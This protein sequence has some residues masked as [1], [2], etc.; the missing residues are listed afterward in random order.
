MKAVP[1]LPCKGVQR[2]CACGKHTEGC[3][4]TRSFRSPTCAPCVENRNM[5]L[6][7]AHDLEDRLRTVM[8]DW[9]TFWGAFIPEDELTGGDFTL[10][11][12]TLGKLEDEL[13]HRGDAA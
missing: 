5:H 7:L 3:T 1:S 9:L 4:T 6:S 11:M 13:L 12:E 8:S 2:C 10:A